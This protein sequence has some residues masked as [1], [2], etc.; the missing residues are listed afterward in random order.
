VPARN[1][2]S[3]R[4]AIPA[5]RVAEREGKSTTYGSATAARPVLHLHRPARL[6]MAGRAARLHKDVQNQP[7]WP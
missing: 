6:P 2:G 3:C 1:T 4:C 7:R 5:Q